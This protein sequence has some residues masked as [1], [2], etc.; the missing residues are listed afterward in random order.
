[1]IKTLGIIILIFCT[2][3]IGY[4]ASLKLSMR[5]KFF[6]NYISFLEFFKAQ[7]SFASLAF[8]EILERFA[9][10][11]EFKIFKKLL[12]ETLKKEKEISKAWDH[13]ILRVKDVFGLTS[14]D[15]SIIS[16]F[17]EEIGVTD[18][19]NQLNLCNTHIHFA[20]EHFKEAKARK[21]QM[22]RLYI[23]LGLWSGLAF[24][25]LLL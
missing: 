16:V 4:Q 3:A 12:K 24:S 17:G 9:P 2:S 6:E 22:S 23:T 8:S 18:I 15:I 10:K 7:I 19:K 20:Q 25:I 1:M 5:K 11:D 14:S 13:S 21:N